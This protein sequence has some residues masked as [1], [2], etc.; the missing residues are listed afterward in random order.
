MGR[1]EKKHGEKMRSN[2]T[3]PPPF[4]S[5]FFLASLPPSFLLVII[6]IAPFAF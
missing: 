3:L 4:P 5:F 2:E 6:S 1:E